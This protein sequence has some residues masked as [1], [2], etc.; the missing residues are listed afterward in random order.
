M[1]S[2]GCHNRAQF[3]AS[4]PAQDGHYRDGYTRTPRMIAV[5]HVMTT[6]CQYTHT[7]L[8]QSDAKCIGCKHKSTKGNE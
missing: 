8:G 6:L 5:P 4:E 1:S 7:E 3:R 2:Y